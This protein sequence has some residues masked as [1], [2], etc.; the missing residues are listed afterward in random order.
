MNADENAV[1]SV[2]EDYQIALN[3]SDTEAALELYRTL[4]FAKAVG[5]GH[6]YPVAQRLRLSLMTELGIEP[7]P[8]ED[9]D[10]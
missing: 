7:P 3:R 6:E 8:P 10:E 1:A 2:L 5:T 9:P 4:A